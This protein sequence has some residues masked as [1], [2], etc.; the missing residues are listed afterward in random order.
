ML[1][2]AIWPKTKADEDKMSVG[3]KNMCEEDHTI[4]LDKNAETHE[5]VLYSL[6]D[7]HTDLILS[8]LKSKYKVEVTTSIPT[9]QYRETIR[10]K[11]EAQGRIRNRTAAPVSLV[12]C[13][14]ASNRLTVMKWYSQRKSSA[15]LYRSSTSRR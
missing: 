1:G 9:V 4:R 2:Y 10:G 14:S 12:K 15:V 5:Q 13:L 11:A 6:G 7:Q 3:I 8:K